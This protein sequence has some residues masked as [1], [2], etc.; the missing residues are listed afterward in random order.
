MSDAAGTRASRR[1]WLFFAVLTI[2]LALNLFFLG[3]IAGSLPAMHHEGRGH[4]RFERI[5]GGMAL[6]PPQLAAFRDFQKILRQHGAAMHRANMG[7]WTKI[8]DPATGQ[9]Q[10]A[11]LLDSAVKNR[12]DFQHDV[13]GA[14]TKFLGLLTPA[15]RAEFVREA[16]ATPHPHG[17]LHRLRELFR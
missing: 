16:R 4:D 9:D 10:L 15:Q 2:S 3:V 17:P 14:L 13:S 7:V 5:V 11:P 6:S 8:A 12:D 1:G